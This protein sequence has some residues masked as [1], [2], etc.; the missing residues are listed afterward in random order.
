MIDTTKLNA[1]QKQIYQQFKDDPDF[2]MEKALARFAKAPTQ[3]RKVQKV[4]DTK[5]AAS[6]ELR[7]VIELLHRKIELV[8]RA[9]G[10]CGRT[11]A[12]DFLYVAFCSDSCRATNLFNT[13]GI[14]WDIDKSEKERWGGEPPSVIKPKT[15]QRLVAFAESILCIPDA[16]HYAGRSI[17]HGSSHAATEQPDRVQTHTNNE[18][19][20]VS[21][22]VLDRE[23]HNIP[24]TRVSASK[25]PVEAVKEVRESE[26]V[27]A[28]KLKLKSGE[29]SKIEYQLAL[30]DLF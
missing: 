21:E 7:L 14:A 4:T 29:L 26:E 28:L 22:A 9:C 23:V 10:E 25:N 20:G 12:C 11:F 8:Q 30:A 1:K 19:Y 15:L 17:N 27:A 18:S 2:D 5:E 16:A 3:A 6:R 13:T 24:P